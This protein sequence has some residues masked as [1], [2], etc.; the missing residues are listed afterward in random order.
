MGDMGDYWRDL[1]DM[2]REL[3]DELGVKCPGCI[4]QFPKREPTILLPHQRCKVCSYRDPRKRV[5]T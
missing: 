1:K 5:A 4:T 2:R 3:R